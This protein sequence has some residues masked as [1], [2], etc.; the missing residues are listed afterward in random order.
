MSPIRLTVNHKLCSASRLHG[1]TST[2]GLVRGR[3]RVFL[4]LAEASSGFSLRIL[5]QAILR[6]ISSMKFWIAQAQSVYRTLNVTFFHLVYYG[7]FGH[8]H[9]FS[10]FAFAPKKRAGTVVAAN[11]FLTEQRCATIFF[12]IW[13]EEPESEKGKE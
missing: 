6:V 5:D 12:S 7:V 1:L 11:E 10:E 3:E 13:A 8:S 4:L 2:E 9:E